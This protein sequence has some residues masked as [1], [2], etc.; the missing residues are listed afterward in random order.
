MPEFKALLIDMDNTLLLFDEDEF[1]MAY[2]KL[3]ASFFSD[4]MDEI[5]FIR[6]LLASTFHMLKNDGS[7]TNSEA[8]ARHFAADVPQLD[9]EECRSRF[10]QFYHEAFPKLRKVTIPAPHGR[11]VVESALREG[12]QVAIATNPVFPELASRQR[13]T[14]ANL[15]GLDIAFVTHADNMHYC[16]PLPQ[17]YQR[18]LRELGRQ[19]QECIMAGNDPTS[20]MAASLLGIKTFFVERHTNTP[21]KA[22]TGAISAQVARHAREAGHP[23]EYH[24]DW[25][26]TL[27]DLEQLIT[28]K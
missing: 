16:K 6:K 26:G 23:T 22:K 27:K 14:W 24:I 17:Y 8:F 10:D 28:G 19:P 11:Q 25:R 15:E 1:I 4:L 3:A 9:Y 13:L 7:M 21:I 2:A 12:L 18:I 5:T 20:D